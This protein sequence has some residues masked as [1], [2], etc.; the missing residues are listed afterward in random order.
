MDK[1]KK[2]YI[3][4]FF[5]ISILG[6]FMH[7]LFELSNRNLIIA[8]FSAVNESV[9]EHLKI[10]VLPTIIFSIFGYKYI[11]DINKKNF[12][13]ALF[14]QII[15]EMVIVS[16]VFYLYTFLIGKSVLAIDIFLFFLSIFISS[17]VSYKILSSNINNN[18]SG[19]YILLVLF[20]FLAFIAFTYVTPKLEIFKD[21]KS[22]T[23]G[24]FNEY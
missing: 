17:I 11:E 4:G 21:V 2:L 22:K 5:V 23:Y 8:A 13:K 6:V 18:Y 7:F 10:I 20:V 14:F 12:A 3:I 9:W 1:T 24:V 16:S 15:S 19:I